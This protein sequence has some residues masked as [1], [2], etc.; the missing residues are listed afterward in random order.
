MVILTEEAFLG[1]QCVE[2]PR[3]AFLRQDGVAFG[4]GPLPYSPRL[5]LRNFTELSSGTRTFHLTPRD[6]RPREGR[7][8]GPRPHSMSGRPTAGPTASLTSTSV[9]SVTSTN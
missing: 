6:L 1:A 9:T 3:G 2:Q 5:S 7:A 4:V 8:S